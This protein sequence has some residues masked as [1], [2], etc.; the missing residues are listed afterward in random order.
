MELRVGCHVRSASLQSEQTR[1][2][3][4]QVKTQEKPLQHLQKSNSVVKKGEG[5]EAGMFDP[6]V[7]GTHNGRRKMELL[8]IMLLVAS[9]L[10]ASASV[11]QEVE[12]LYDMKLQLNANGSQLLDWTADN[13]EPCI[14]TSITCDS[15]NNVVEIKIASAGFSGVLSPRIAELKYLNV[16]SL[17][18][19][20]ITGDIPEQFGTLSR[21]TSLNLE[22]NLLVGEMPAS[23][24]QLSK[25]Q[26]LILSQNNLNGSIPDTLA[27]ISSLTESATI[28][29]LV[30]YLV[31]CFKLQVTSTVR[32][33]NALDPRLLSFGANNGASRGSKIGIVLGTVG[34]V[35][36][37]LILGAL[38]IL[39]NRRVRHPCEVFVD[40]SGDTRR[41]AFGQ[42]KTFAF[43]ELEIAT[44]N[45]SEKNVLGQGGFGKVYKGM[46]LDGTMVA[47][48]RLTDYRSPGGEVAFLSEVELISIA[49][50][51]NLLRLIGFCTTQTERLLVYPFM[52]NLSVAYRLR[53]FEPG[54]SIFDW[55]ARKGVARGTARGLEYLHEHCNPKIIHRDVKAANVLLDED[56]EPVVGDFGLAK[57]VDVRVTSVTTKV[58]GTMGHIAPEY[59]FTGKSSERTDVF[60][61]GIMLFELV[62]G[63]RAIDFPDMVDEDDVLFLDHFKKLQREGYLNTIVDPNLNGS[64]DEQEVEMMVQIAL[65]CTQTYPEDRPS[66]SE[67]VRLLD[68]EGLAERWEVCQ[69]AVTR[70]QE[71]ELM[72]QRYDRGEESRYIQE[73]I[74]L[75]AGR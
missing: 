55:S 57:L 12:A 17:P 70:R 31:N 18:G 72:Q 11:P 36:G 63:K 8:S 20:N 60:G 39:L 52:Q 67:V 14:W 1:H 10:P 48:K 54:E 30:I 40:A 71:Y 27:G 5:K 49:V 43:Q 2:G 32:S 25:L 7:T 26:L 65:L 68:G 23:L 13:I 6:T 50:H 45:F 41:T 44:G 61:Y 59:L 51:R 74:E 46:L 69:Q 28:T 16:L 38:F 33:L 64:Y 19:N 75:S 29:S 73:A 42:L 66:M 15:S 24:G 35:M 62:T 34:G 21:L 3:E 58:C 4:A 56:F 9:L 37:L 22:G 53:G 47:V